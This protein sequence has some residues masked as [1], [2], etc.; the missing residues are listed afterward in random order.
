MEDTLLK[1]LTSE[2]GPIPGEK[3]IEISSISG[4]CIHKAWHIELKNGQ[5]L[6]AKTSP[7]EAFPMLKFEAECLKKLKEFA[8][9]DL[10]LIPEPLAIKKLKNHSILLLPWLKLN[11]SHQK[12]LG[13]GL[14]YLHKT[15]TANNPKKFGWATDGFIGREI[16][17]GGWENNWGKCFANL[18]LL[19]QFQKASSWGLNSNQYKKIIAELIPFL[20]QHQPE[21]SLVHGDL[22]IGNCAIN[23][24]SKGVLFDPASWWAD[25]EVDI[26]MTKLFGGFSDEFYQGYK[27]IWELPK[28]SGNRT[29]IYNLYHLINHANM[30]GGSYK[31]QSLSLLKTISEQLGI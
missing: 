3:I 9:K 23:Q 22:W 18:R 4:G 31:N 16:Q 1:T 2:E 13:Q 30:F 8:N 21:P 7:P 19:P 17:K 10:L 6:F 5:Q 29:N 27:E 20:N 15:S 28:S 12:I 11:N 14:A 26:A 25:R 24:N